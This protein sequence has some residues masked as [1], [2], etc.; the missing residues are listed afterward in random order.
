MTVKNKQ[1]LIIFGIF[2][3]GMCV[4]KSE[5]VRQIQNLCEAAKF[6]GKCI[7]DSVSKTHTKPV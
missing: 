3:L 5:S 4:S 7:L 1:K 2:S 6:S